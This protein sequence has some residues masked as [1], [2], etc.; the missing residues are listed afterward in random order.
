MSTPSKSSDDGAAKK[1]A[2]RRLWDALHGFFASP[3]RG[4][5]AV[6]GVFGVLGLSFVAAEEANIRLNT[7]E[8]CLSCHSMSYVYEEFKQ[9]KHYTNASG[10]RP[11]CGQCHVARRFFPAMWDHVMGTHDLIAELSNDWGTVEKFDAGRSRMAERARLKMLAEDSHTCRECHKM[12][13]IAPTRKRGQR[14]HDDAVAKGRSNCIA[15]HYNLVHKEAP[16]TPAFT[17]A[18]K[19]A[20]G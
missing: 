12:E 5:L 17:Q 2:T 20:G 18:I 15:C 7:T 3:L 4:V 13:A 9:S 19:A 16:L 6:V 8:F 1:P 11:E 14:A 10:V